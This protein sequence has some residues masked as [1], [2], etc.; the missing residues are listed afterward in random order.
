MQV[1]IMCALLA[2]TA[3][4]AASVAIWGS[5]LGCKV[6]CCGRPA[7]GVCLNSLLLIVFF[8]T[9]RKYK[10][11]IFQV[12]TDLESQRVGVREMLENFV[13]C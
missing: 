11:I 3:V 5:V 4:T 6:T 1:G 9:C 10:I 13:G 2:V 12:P 8:V 7:T